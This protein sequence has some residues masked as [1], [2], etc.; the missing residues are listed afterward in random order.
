MEI[1]EIR[2]GWG[3]NCGMSIVRAFWIFAAIVAVAVCAAGGGLAADLPSISDE[4]RAFREDR[5]RWFH[6]MLASMFFLFGLRHAPI[7]MK[8]LNVRGGN[9]V[10]AALFLIALASVGFSAVIGAI[11]I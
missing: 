6:I 11:I 3:Y 1:W 7:W 5:E 10:I 8:R 2:L 4:F 9:A